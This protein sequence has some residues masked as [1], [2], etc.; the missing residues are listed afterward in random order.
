MYCSGC[1]QQITPGQQVCAHC[2]R[3]TASVPPP[4]APPIPNI[5]FELANYANRVRALSTVWFI[6]GGLVLVT[7]MIGLSFASS[8]LNGG[9]GPW[10][11]GPWA[12]GGF[13]FGPEFGPAILHFAWVMV[14]LRAAL[15]FVAGWGLM[16][17]APW[18]RVVAIV[19]AFLSIL[20]IPIGTALAIWTLVTL[21]GYRN[22]TLYDQL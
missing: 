1:G 9:F 16:E 6:Y 8:F 15:A 5:A 22:T 10:M 7:G 12:H 18:G 21:L 4:P 2:G 14:I 3:P 19:A 17:R 11:R 13:P 20:K